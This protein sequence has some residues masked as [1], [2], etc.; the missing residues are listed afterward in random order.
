M[1]YVVAL[2]VVATV[3]FAGTKPVINEMYIDNGTAVPSYGNDWRDGYLVDSSANQYTLALTHQEC[4]SYNETADAI[5]VVNRDYQVSG[6]LNVHSADGGLSFWM[7][8]WSVYGQDF[9][10][11]RYPTAIA[12]D[13]APYISF[14]YLYSGAWGGG[15]GQYCSGGWYSS[16]WDPAIDLYPGNG[17]V[18]TVIGKEMPNGNMCFILYGT[19]PFQLYYRTYTPDLGT[20]LSQG[21]LSA[22]ATYYWGW[23]SNLNAGIAYVFYCDD[24]LNVYYR[25]STDGVTWTSEASYNLV[26]PNPYTNNLIDLS[27]GVQACVKDDGNPVLVFDN[28]NGDDGTYPPYSKVYVSTASGAA[29]TQVSPTGADSERY[30]VTIGTAGTKV[31]V[32]YCQ[33]RNNLDDSLTWLDV[34][35]T[36]SENG[37]TTW[38]TPVNQTSDHTRRTCIPQLSKRLDAARNRGYMLYGNAIGS[39][40]D[41]MWAYDAQS[42]RATRIYFQTVSATGVAEN[43]SELPT[44]IALNVKPNPVRGHAALTYS[45]PN[46]GNVS[47]KLFS[48]DGRLVRELE[49]GTRET[50]VYTVNI[51]TSDLVSGTYFVVL[52]TAGNT[53]SSTMVVTR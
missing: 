11:G 20:L 22:A 27:T 42:A 44:R 25:T 52:E 12:A 50:G 34:F 8:D 9:G 43:K 10:P 45:L 33:P 24:A 16:A 41:L 29:C 51:G 5:A 3:M 53:I 48:T 14:P 49:H 26:W 13:A 31:G 6:V 35:Y 37:G 2:L 30:Y 19:S 32:I 38:S 39:D 23:D 1:K 7:D 21:T 15:G 46:A 36:Q 4:I 28:R 47:L 18:Q 40:V 17:F